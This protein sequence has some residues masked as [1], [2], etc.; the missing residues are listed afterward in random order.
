MCRVL[1]SDEHSIYFIRNLF[2]SNTGNY[3]GTF[4]IKLNREKWMQY[5]V[6]GLDPSWFIC[7][8]NQEM[9]LV[10]NDAMNAQ[11]AELAEHFTAEPSS[12]VLFREVMLGGESYFA[13][14]EQL[15]GP[16]DRNPVDGDS[17]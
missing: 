15:P 14:S 9:T 7:L 13:A 3:M 17:F 1:P 16:V 8:Y 12:S 6:E 2:N 5:C 4:F 10:S 11:G